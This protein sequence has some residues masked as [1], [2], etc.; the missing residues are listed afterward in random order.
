MLPRTIYGKTKKGTV[1]NFFIL[2]NRQ[3]IKT[4]N[5][6]K[7]SFISPCGDNL[8]GKVTYVEHLSPHLKCR[9]IVSEN[10][11]SGTSSPDKE[12]ACLRKSIKRINYHPSSPLV[13]YSRM[14]INSIKGTEKCTVYKLRSL[15]VKSF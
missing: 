6:L 15:L 7:I 4:K 5:Q 14:S 12:T 10:H 3:P 11:S 1:N 2:S 8:S 9:Q 13:I